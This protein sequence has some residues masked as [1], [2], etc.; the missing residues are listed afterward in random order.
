MKPGNN[1]ISIIDST[2]RDGEQAPGVSFSR[3]DKL[4]LAVMLAEAGVDELEAGIPAMGEGERNCIRDMVKLRL[5]CRITSWCRAK[6]ED[7]EAASESGTEGVH[8]GFPV[9]PI[10]LRTIG[11]N[12]DW[13]LNKLEEL[14]PAA[15]RLFPMVSVGAIDS[16]RADLSF[17]KKFAGLASSYGSYRLRIADTV[18]IASPVK[19]MD[20]I[21]TLSADAE[22]MIL[23]FHGHN[24]LGMATA[25][26]ISA[27]MAGAKALSVTVNGLGER[28]GNVPL[29]EIA[30]AMPICTGK[31]C[32]IHPHSLLPLSNFVSQISNRAI[33]VN[34][35]ITGDLIFTHESGIHCHA[36]LKDDLSYQPFSPRRIGREDTKF[37]IG[38]H[39]GSAVICHVLQHEK[40]PVD[41][42][43]ARLLL[44]KVRIS[45]KE[46]NLV[47]SDEKNEEL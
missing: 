39:S 25:N 32:N 7:I 23:E 36:L 16:F 12:E 3:Q 2:L 24:D 40:I 37:V 18:G 11:E 44:E 1:N 8:I 27:V 30:V 46:K 35:P 42:N 33:P 15:C 41:R 43:N 10:L 34:K 14:V 38:K 22:A 29:E 47:K 26:A 13:V 17:L 19:V 9:S 21:G 6:R 20:L 28:A 5:P 31:S 4:R 45:V